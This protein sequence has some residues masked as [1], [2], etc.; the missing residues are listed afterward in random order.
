M[1]ARVALI[2]VILGLLVG[3]SAA[4]VAAASLTVNSLTDGAPADDG[5]CTMREAIIAANTDTASGAMVG[6]CAAGSGADVISF[7]VSGTI[8]LGAALPNITSDL[9][10]PGGGAITVSGANNFRVFFVASGTVTLSGLTITQGHATSGVLARGGGI[11]NSGTLT[12]TNSTITNNFTDFS[13][14][15]GVGGGIYNSGSLSVTNSTISDNNAGYN[16]GGISNDGTM[17]IVDST[18][19]GNFAATFGGGISNLGTATVTNSSID[20]NDTVDADGGGIANL[21][22]LNVTGSTISGNSSANGAGGG[23]SSSG[24]VTVTGSTISGNSA[25]NYGGGIWNAFGSTLTVNGSTI[26]GNAAV[27]GTG[28]GIFN[29]NFGA[30]TVTNSTFSGNQSGG[31][32]GGISN[33][34]ISATL[35]L[36]NSTISGNVALQSAGGLYGLGIETVVNSIIAGNAAG[37]LGQEI[38]DV[39]DT[40]TT[41]VIGVPGGLTLADILVPAGLANNGGPTQT[42]AL[43]QVAANPAI[44]TGTGAACAAAPVNGLDQR[45]LP[46]PTACDMGAYEIQ[47]APVASS[48]PNAALPEPGPM[49]GWTTLGF[50]ALLIGALGAVVLVGARGAR[51]RP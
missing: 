23:I 34:G 11:Y 45:G 22:S 39:I 8:T 27:Q 9:S 36:T 19:N 51:A 18:I 33:G 2:L 6:E 31:N 28:G 30:L 1:R 4:P 3:L 37:T 5:S 50:V 25:F 15:V 48:L 49:S 14:G 46:R 43:A 12:L 13:P 42:I 21:G 16:G 26:S 32:G 29:D 20:G 35:T 41:S 10:I 17:T 40:V 44:D 38:A 47:P 24:T 7:S